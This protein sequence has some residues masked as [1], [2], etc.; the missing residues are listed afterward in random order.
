MAVLSN[1]STPTYAY[2]IVAPEKPLDA[3]AIKMLNVSAR[4]MGEF[5]VRSLPRNS[6]Y[7]SASLELDVFIQYVGI[8]KKDLT[9]IQFNPRQTRW[10]TGNALVPV[11]SQYQVQY[12]HIQ[13]W[14]TAVGASFW[15][16]ITLSYQG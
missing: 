11:K 7:T 14:Q 1:S 16:D 15:D 9:R 4:V 3:G 13:L 12:V 8:G 6:T 5:V 10:Q 2:Q